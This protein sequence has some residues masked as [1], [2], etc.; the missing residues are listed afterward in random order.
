MQIE[1]INKTNK[2]E[3]KAK[4]GNESTTTNNEGSQVHR[5]SHYNDIVFISK[6]GTVHQQMGQKS[7]EFGGEEGQ[8]KIR[9]KGSQSSLKTTALGDGHGAQAYA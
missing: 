1:D 6:G 9:L 7:S 2:D 5:K 3:E 8:Y 4:Q